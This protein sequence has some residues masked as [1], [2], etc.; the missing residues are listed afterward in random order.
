MDT[1]N[2]F[3]ILSKCSIDSLNSP[4][5]NPTSHSSPVTDNP[6][7]QHTHRHNPRDS[8]KYST[9]SLHNRT[10]LTSSSSIGPST[11][12]YHESSSSNT[13][14]KFTPKKNNWRTLIMNSNSIKCRKAELD[15]ITDYVK[16]DAIIVTE[17]KLD[18]TVG[19]AEFMPPGYNCF[20]KDRSFDGGGV[21]IAIKSC[22]PAVDAE[23]KSDSELIWVTV[24]MRN[25]RKITIGS[26]YRP[27]DKGIDPIEG[28][29]QSLSSL[30]YK[31]CKNTTILLGGDFNLPHID[32]NS[33][34]VS[35]SCP[36]KQAHE[37]LLE[38]LSDHHLTQMQQEP[39]R[40]NDILD[41]FCT[42]KPGLVRYT[43]TIPGFSDH[44]FIV[45]DCDLRPQFIKNMP[46]KVYTYS[47]AK[48]DD[49]RKEL[50]S[51][52]DEYSRDFDNRTVDKNWD[53]FKT[54]LSNLSDKYIPSRMTSTKQHLPWL[55]STT[56]R[57]CRRKQRLYNLARRTK[58]TKHWER[59]KEAKKN[60]C[61]AL[62]RAHLNYINDIFEE[63]I[64][65]NDTKP[66]W[67]YVKSQR[68]E[69]VG[70]APLKANGQLHSD[71]ATKANILSQQF[72]SVFT[73]EDGATPQRA[74]LTPKSN[75]LFPTRVL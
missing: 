32:W 34:S 44:D 51:S 62:R 38:V 54:I 47:R 23:I 3:S 26:F 58:K 25:E 4:V 42:N 60:T 33:N 22:Y 36:N 10:N 19:N 39:T 43:Q 46:R 6:Q 75:T 16:P 50:N 57:M 13:S 55:N 11:P 72:Q 24:S 56:K 15:Y 31:R 59:F 41:L 29:N 40:N 48:W 66:F 69:N 8:A 30:N 67:R 49:M 61:N 65:N 1:K 35:P 63:G 21:M 73:Q 74:S 64:S 68:Q 2:S 5:F 17:T 53:S 7:R 14:S 52:I 27:P 28:L 45:V 18:S 9:S 37:R 70:V 12:S 71:S 20:R